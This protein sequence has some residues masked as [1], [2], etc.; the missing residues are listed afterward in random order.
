MEEIKEK[1]NKFKKIYLTIP[2]VIVI[3]IL[4]VVYLNIGNLNKT[5][6][7]TVSTGDNVS[8]YYQLSL[9][10]GSIIQS[11]F[12]KSP[13]SFVVGSGDVISGF[14]NAVIG[15]K[16][17]Q[18][19]NVTLSPSEAYGEVNNS[20]IITV[21]RTEFGNNSLKLGESIRSSTGEIGVITYLNNTNVTIDFN[22][23]L[24]GKTLIF[25]IEFL[26]IKNSQ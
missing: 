17:G 15:M 19:K 12:G 16:V 7:I 24:A 20:L 4:L 14:N 10:N 18:T 11:N 26:S 8:V 2:I 22:S 5:N 1:K 25:K 3:V 9:T 13:F 23:P 6:V 21:P